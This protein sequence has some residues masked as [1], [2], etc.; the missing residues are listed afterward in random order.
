MAA[1]YNKLWKLLI[2][3]G[4]KKK[5]LQAAAGISSGVITKL[6]TGSA[7]YHNPVQIKC[8]TPGEYLCDVAF[9]QCKVTPYLQNSLM[10]TFKVLSISVYHYIS[11]TLKTQYKS[12]L[13]PLIRK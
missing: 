9:G 5:D 11:K 12:G 10:K 1:N 7:I 6:G 8:Q 3:K 2:D 13:Y 4:M